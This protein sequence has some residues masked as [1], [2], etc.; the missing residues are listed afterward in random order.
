MQLAFYQREKKLSDNNE[1]ENLKLSWKDYLAIV[2]AALQTTLLPF[3]L[4][5]IAMIIIMLIFI[6]L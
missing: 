4:L 5:L 6:N 2:V 1:K 3:I